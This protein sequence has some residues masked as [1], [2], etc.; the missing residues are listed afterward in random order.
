MAFCIFD[1]ET[2]ARD[3]A[4]TLVREPSAA[5]STNIVELVAVEREV[6]HEG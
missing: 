2:I 5:G 6:G 3:G 1:L 4:E